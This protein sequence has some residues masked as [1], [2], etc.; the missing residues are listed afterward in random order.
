MKKII[1]GL[2]VSVSSFY[3]HAYNPTMDPAIKNV[4]GCLSA[5]GVF[6]CN[7]E[8]N[9]ILSSLSM[10]VRGEFA[11]YLREKLQTNKNELVIN[12][13]YT[14]LKELADLYETLDSSSNWSW[15]AIKN[16]LDDVAIEYV[17]IAPIDQEFLTKLYKNQGAL[18][19]RY[20]LLTTLN[21][22][23]EGLTE[24]SE[25]ENLIRFLEVA[26]DY[27]RL[28][29]DEQYV[30]NTAVE[31]IKKVTQKEMDIRPGHEGV[32]SLTF[33]NPE[34]AAG[35]KIDRLVV[36]ESNAKDALVVSFVAS[37]TRVVKMSFT[38]ALILGDTIS[39]NLDIYNNVQDTA[40][41][42]FKFVLDR[43]GNVIKG[44]FSTARYGVLNF[45]GSLLE[46]NVAIYNE[47]TVK[48]LDIEQLIG[49]Y[50]VKVDD[51]SMQ[52][53]IRKRTDDRSIVEA[54]LYNDNAMISFSKV[55]LNSQKGVL[56]LVDI[57]NERKLTL[58]IV[59][60]QKGPIFKGQFVNAPQAKVF[61]VLTE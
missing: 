23:I 31:M 39:S 18:S 2:L 17:K 6:I 37:T 33:D 32:F 38:G 10:D 13:L 58:A 48:N 40:N 16:L 1:I 44:V 19:G 43:K 14:K 22:K 24:L 46:S 26:K 57:N 27:S 21:D 45:S 30:Y 42:F 49:S 56:S 8:I 54:A 5:S 4:E 61:K 9:G 50:K 28:I 29:R 25:M 52:L 60:M 36:M 41:P 20:G 55:T 53:I 11:M 15:R 7:T 12:N 3:A 34:M 51:H 35:L 47:N 59:D